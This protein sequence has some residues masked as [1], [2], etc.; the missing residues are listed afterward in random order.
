MAN[1]KDRISFLTENLYNFLWFNRNKT[2][3]FSYEN[4]IIGCFEQFSG[5]LM[6]LLTLR[7]LAN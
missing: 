4:V 7:F 6:E 2:L 3:F 1:L 5:R